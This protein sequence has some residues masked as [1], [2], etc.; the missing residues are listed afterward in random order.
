MSPR[1]VL[2]I[3]LD[4]ATFDL[5]LPWV[6]AGKLPAFARILSGGAWGPLKSTVPPMTFPAWT[7][8]MTGKNPGKHGVYDFTEREPGGYGIRFVN[9]NWVKSKTIWRLLSDAGRRVAVLSLPVTYPPE[10]VNGVM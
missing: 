4:G 1:R 8:L 3:G 5:I 9:A 2:M 10:P 7:S 6:E